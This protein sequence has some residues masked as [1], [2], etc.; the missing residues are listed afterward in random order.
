MFIL[1]NFHTK[2]KDIKNNYDFNRLAY[3]SLNLSSW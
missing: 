3:R 2:S 1:S